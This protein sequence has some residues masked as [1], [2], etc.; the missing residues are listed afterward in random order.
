[1]PSGRRRDCGKGRSLAQEVGEMLMLQQHD[2]LVLLPDLGS[3]SR[4]AFIGFECLGFAEV[5]AALATRVSWD[6]ERS[7]L[8]MHLHENICLRFW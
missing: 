7:P 4:M 6:D 8:N 5:V 2:A 1:M 3:A